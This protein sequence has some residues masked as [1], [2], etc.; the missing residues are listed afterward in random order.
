MI[1]LSNI[2]A[3]AFLLAAWSMPDVVLAA[4]AGGD[5]PQRSVVRRDAQALP[6]TPAVWIGV[7][8]S[9]VP[10]PLAAHVGEAG[11]MIVNIVKDGP[12]DRA[13]LQRYDIIR[14]FDGQ[15]LHDSADLVNA[16]A[17]VGAG[18]D[19]EIVVLH[20]GERKTL[21]ITPADRSDSHEVEFVYDEPI[22]ELDNVFRMRGHRLLTDPRGR[23]T[24]EHLGP[25]PGFPDSLRQLLDER[26]DWQKLRG[27]LDLNGVDGDFR[28]FM[29]PGSGWF[30][31]SS[32]SDVEA[33]VEVRVQV[34]DDG[35]VTTIQRAADGTITIERRTP[36]GQ[37][38]STQYENLDELRENDPDA[39]ELFQGA[40]SP[41]SIMIQT[42]PRVDDLGR[43]QKDFQVQVEAK[44]RQAL[45]RS[46]QEFE[47][48][49]QALDR[50]NETLDQQIEAGTV[51][52]IKGKHS[53]RD[54][55]D[56]APVESVSFSIGADGRITV[57]S[58]ADGRREV[59]VFDSVQ[60]F[61]ES[62][63]GLYDKVRNLLE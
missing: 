17:A 24:L 25:L 14:S 56:G 8:L 55:P 6:E 57:E 37:E 58:V 19:A 31:D 20:G 18:H 2:V 11:L 41:R 54:R 51:K 48:A 23:W 27:D 59:H 5:G 26:L 62:A 22:E 50:A 45:E 49:R 46:R 42:R 40:A 35:Q 21:M 9:P 60:E 13:G 15:Q 33:R 63:P 12:A 53:L 47:Q 4:S 3:H 29:Q 39:Y 43:K 30:S 44:L 61:R 10:A 7:R 52:I 1:L 38:S 28:I 16:I 32:Q 36:D 34:D